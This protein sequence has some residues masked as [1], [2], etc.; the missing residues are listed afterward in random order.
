MQFLCNGLEDDMMS[1]R[2]QAGAKDTELNSLINA[3]GKMVLL[4][5]LLPKLQREGR[6][7]K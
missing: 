2:L 7:V 5:K 1:R 6:K 3:S 4:F